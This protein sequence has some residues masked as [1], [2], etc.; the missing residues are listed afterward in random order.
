MRWIAVK[1]FISLTKINLLLASLALLCCSSVIA[2]ESASPSAKKQL[3]EVIPITAANLR[4]QK[5]LYKEGWFI[6]SS[7]ERAFQY[8]HEKSIISSGQ[9]LQ[10]MQANITQHSQELP[11]TLSTGIRAGQEQ[12]E[13]LYQQ[14]TERSR[15]ILHNTHGIAQQQLDYSQQGFVKAWDHFVLGNLTLLER[16]AEDRMALQ[17]IPGDYFSTL[18]DDFS[19]LFLLNK[20][21]VDTIS[22]EIEVN[23][24]DSFQQAQNAF[25]DAYQASGNES[26]SLMGLRNIIGGYGKALYYGLFKP[27]S[28]SVI[29]GATVTAGLAGQALFL[30]TASLFIVSGRTVQS[31]G[32]SLYYTSKNGYKVVSPSIESGLLAGVSLLAVGTVP[33]TYATGA[34]VGVLNQV[35]IMTAAPIIGSAVAGGNTLGETAK[36]AGLV[37]Y[38]LAKGSSKVILNQAASGLVLGYNA[39]TALPAQTLLTAVNGTF[40]LVF[41][42]PR[43][44]IAKVNGELI[45]SDG[46]SHAITTLPIGSVLDMKKLEQLPGVEIKSISDDPKVIEQVLK[47]IPEDLRR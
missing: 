21:M 47:N 29:K 36:Y 37:S 24:T 16:T 9:A 32:L 39:L 8:A 31:I 38:D 12:G 30:P 23:W 44:M 27:S 46:T 43:L 35:A 19:N 5:S 18:K 6:V 33:L 7:T 4:G 40:F 11:K 45:S 20:Q 41:D 34:S 1:P 13:T 28:D 25:N 26:N 2:E 14:G 3:E 17:A 22:P 42:G 15:N 10:Q